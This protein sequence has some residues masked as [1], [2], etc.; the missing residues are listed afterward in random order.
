MPTLTFKTSASEARS[1]RRAA[2]AKRM[3]LSAYARHMMLDAPR[4]APEKKQTDKIKP[5][6][7]VVATP[8][9]TPEMLD[10]VIYDYGL[11]Y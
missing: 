5:G 3:T 10:A 7:A 4:R 1:I 2:Q 11:P 9:I 8:L 6:R